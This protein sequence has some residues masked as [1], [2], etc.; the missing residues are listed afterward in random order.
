MSV[1]K[2]FN[3]RRKNVIK[4]EAEKIPKYKDLRTQIECMWDLK[5]KVIP[6]IKGQLL[7]SQHH[8]ENA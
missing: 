8:S 7:P 3:F 4:K 5:T 2:S 1:Y 6:V